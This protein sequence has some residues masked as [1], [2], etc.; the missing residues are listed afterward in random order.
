MSCL[1][2]IQ[3]DEPANLLHWTEAGAFMERALDAGEHF[4]GANLAF[5]WSVMAANFPGLLPKIFQ[6]YRE[7]R[8]QDVIIR[9]KLLDIAAGCYRGYLNSKW[10][11]IQFNYDLASL[12]R[13]H[14]EL[15]LNKDKEIQLTFG[16]LRDLPLEDWPEQHVIYSLEDTTATRLVWVKQDDMIRNNP[17]VPLLDDQYRQVQADFALRLMSTWGLRTDAA[18]VDNLERLTLAEYSR[19]EKLLQ[20]EGLV[21]ADGSRDTRVAKD[22]ILSVCGWSQQITYTAI[23]GKK[24]KGKPAFEYTPLPDRTD[25]RKMHLTDSDDVSLSADSC[26]ESDD[27]LLE[28]Y[29]EFGELKSVLSKDIKALRTGVILPI[30]THFGLAASGRVTSS[31]P[32][33]QNWRRLPGIREAFRPREGRVFAQADVEGL[34]LATLAQTC[35]TVIKSSALADAINAG[36]DPHTDLACAILGIPY[37]EGIRRKKLAG[38]KAVQAMFHIRNSE[39]REPIVGVDCTPE[40]FRDYTDAVEFDNAR[41]TAKVAN[42][43][44][45]GG[46]GIKKMVLFA[47][48]TYGVVITEDECRKLK[49]RWLRKWPEMEKF[50]AWINGQ[51]TNPDG[52][53]Q[54]M[55]LFSNRIR[56]GVTYTA[57]CNTFFQGLG[58]D[59]M[60]AATWDLIQACYDD[61]TSVMYGSRPVNMVHDEFITETDDDS[62]AHDV[63]H[64]QE[65]I[66][67]RA[68]KKWLPD[69]R[70]AAPPLLMRRWSKNAKAVH[71]EN[72]RLVPWE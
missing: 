43:G 17:G 28:I 42:F 7:E 59:A 11:W 19:L 70:V 66:M 36:M 49:D 62:C 51:M 45:P 6:A 68:I 24:G 53:G 29:G 14:T 22:R 65:R 27:P 69:L 44:F 41:Q 18:S 47:R 8:C 67:I 4:V 37:E 61:R 46:L 39:Q 40:I 50:F 23:E 5:D 25:T 35:I 3:D 72:G 54:I 30:H 48:A 38:D 16:P 10:K 33:V 60:K 71:D 57:G 15:R 1:S 9:Q 52:T 56:G 64:E 55:Q 2:Y 34:E 26:G 12:A 21:R 32:N 13:R 58:A 20:A 63:A 31:S